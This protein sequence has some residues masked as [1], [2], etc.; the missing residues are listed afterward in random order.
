MPAVSAYTLRP[1]T[2]RVPPQGS[3]IGGAETLEDDARRLAAGIQ[4]GWGQNGLIACPRQPHVLQALP[5]MT[6]EDAKTVTYVAP[7]S[8]QDARATTREVH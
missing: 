1:V 7:H 3:E 4:T 2:V 8:L 6:P 5:R